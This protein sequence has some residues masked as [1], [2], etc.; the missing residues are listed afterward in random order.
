LIRDR[1]LSPVE[2]MQSCLARIERWNPVLRAYI[3]VCAESAMAEAH[4]AERDIAAGRWRGPLHGL[5]FGVKDQLNS[6]GIKTTLG[7]RI[8]ADH[9]PDHDAAVI[10]K[11]KPAPS[12][13][14]RKICT[15]SARAAPSTLPMANRVIRGIS[16]TI[17]R[18]HP[19]ARVLRRRRVFPRD[20]WVK[21][22]AV[23]YA[24][25]HQPMVLSACVRPSAGSAAGA[26]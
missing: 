1:K 7:S 5:P 3:T 19:A 4:L 13:S 15:S 21:T 11:L 10:E 2:L 20:H 12:S 14:A 16:N 17:R 24:A 8:M 25:R 6:K 22:P 9:V 26:A 18:V 23:R